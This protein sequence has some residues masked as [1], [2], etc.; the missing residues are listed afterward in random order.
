MASLLLAPTVP[1]VPGH[2]LATLCRPCPAI[3]YIG[4]LGLEVVLLSTWPTILSDAPSPTRHIMM[5]V[6]GMAN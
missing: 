2:W 3:V 6:K 1:R 4:R 5:E